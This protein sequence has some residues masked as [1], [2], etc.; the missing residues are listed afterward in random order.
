MEYDDWENLHLAAKAV[1][2]CDSG[3]WDG[4]CRCERGYIEFDREQTPLSKV[5]LPQDKKTMSLTRDR[6]PVIFQENPGHLRL[7]R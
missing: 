4:D 3:A 1:L 5:K 2:R 6:Q 7:P